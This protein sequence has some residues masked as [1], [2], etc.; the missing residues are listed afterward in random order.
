MYDKIPEKETSIPFTVYGSSMYCL[1]L[2]K[3]DNTVKKN[4]NTAMTTN[5]RT[6]NKP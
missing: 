2:T 1:P 3:K 5:H 4:Q 6:K